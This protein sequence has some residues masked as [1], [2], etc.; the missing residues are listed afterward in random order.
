MLLLFLH[1]KNDK[2]AKIF[3]EH[4]TRDEVREIVNDSFFL[5]G[6]D[7]ENSQYHE[8]L[9]EALNKRAELSLFID[10]IKSKICAAILIVP[11]K[12]SFVLFSCLRTDISKKDF[13]ET[14]NKAK[15]FL[16]TENEIERD[17]D[18]VEHSEN[19]IGYAWIKSKISVIIF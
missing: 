17:L 15:E 16:R 9:I 10:F 1:N 13:L 4:L 11:V 8:G 18:T 5:L 2:F 14:L 6:W 12:N 3:A 19:D 7:L